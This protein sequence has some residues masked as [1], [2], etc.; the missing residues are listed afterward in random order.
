[1][2]DPTAASGETIPSEAAFE[3]YAGAVER[4]DDHLMAMHRDL[5][6]DKDIMRVLYLVYLGLN[7]FLIEER[8][9]VG[10]RQEA[11]ARGWIAGARP[12]LTRDGLSTLWDWKE[13]VAPRLRDPWFQ[14]LWREVVG[15]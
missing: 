11:R 1:M 10:A 4:R 3:L 7:S 13:Q 15:W 12:S 8:S 6:V 14:S 2:S 9:L 5:S